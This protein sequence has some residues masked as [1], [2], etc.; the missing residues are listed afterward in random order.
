MA[1]DRQATKLAAAIATWPHDWQYEE[2][3]GS[4]LWTRPSNST[5]GKVTAADEALARRVYGRGWSVYPR[6]DGFAASPNFPW[7]TWRSEPQGSGNPYTFWVGAHSET[8]AMHLYETGLE[9]QD[10]DYT[11]GRRRSI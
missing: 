3:R 11:Y 2:D 7:E 1:Q 8:E 4:I 5:S 10:A 6:V 9:M